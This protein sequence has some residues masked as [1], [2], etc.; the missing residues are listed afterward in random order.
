MWR[1]T[2]VE[3]KFCT[4]KR[5][6]SKK[7]DDSL[8]HQINIKVPNFNGNKRL[9]LSFDIWCSRKA[10][11]CLLQT[12]LNHKLNPLP[13]KRN[14]KQTQKKGNNVFLLEAEEN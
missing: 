13:Q 12:I 10:L 7:N 14:V 9:G 3:K 5:W 4:E 6:L 11:E 8:S 1:I 2:H